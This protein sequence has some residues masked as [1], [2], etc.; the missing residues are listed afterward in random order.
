MTQSNALFTWSETAQSEFD[1]VLDGSETSDRFRFALAQTIANGWSSNRDKPVWAL[2]AL[3]AALG[4]VKAGLGTSLDFLWSPAPSMLT[5]LRKSGHTAVQ[6]NEGGSVQL[7]APGGAL[8]VD[9]FRLKLLQK[10]LEFLITCNGFQ[11]AEEIARQLDACL[12]GGLADAATIEASVRM[13]SKIL[14]RYR[15]EHF[16]DGHATSAFSI[17]RAYLA[18]AGDKVTDDSVL[19]FWVSEENS[20][21]RT[22]QA[23]YFAMKDYVDALRGARARSAMRNAA[24]VDAPGIAGALSV[25]FVDPFEREDEGDLDGDGPDLELAAEA[26]ESAAEEAGQGEEAALAAL[27]AI[28]AGTVKILKKKE[29][30]LA[31]PILSAGVFGCAL[32]TAT[33]RLL[34]FHPIQSALSNS[35]R[36]GRATLPL[37]ERVTCVEARTYTALMGEVAELETAMR[38]WLKIALAVRSEEAAA[39]VRAETVRSEGLALLKSRRSQSLARSRAELAEAFAAVE[40]ALVTVARGLG[41]Y[42]AVVLQ[43][44]AGDRLDAGFEADRERFA[45]QLRRLYLVS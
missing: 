41:A 24:E 32:P 35:L 15:T 2:A 22:Y 29:G 4:E 45:A 1:A 18:T 13:I 12:A 14:Y 19:E 44:L 10:Y 31:A 3:L 5:A 34:A 38:D 40:T 25:D 36:T 43:R 9:R 11:H 6:A 33:L 7:R 16:D 30:M 20:Y 27:R 8:M 37:E 26:A 23:S 21:F 42:R 39:D 17:L 28:E